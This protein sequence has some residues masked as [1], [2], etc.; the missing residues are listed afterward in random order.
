[1]NVKRWTAFLA[2]LLGVLL[3]AGCYY[4]PSGAQGPARVSMSLAKGLPVTPSSIALVVSGPGMETIAK[5]LAA[6]SSGS[7]SLE[8]PAGP[9]RTFTFLANTPSVTFKAEATVDLA[10]GETKEIFLSPVLSDT[11]IVVPDPY[12]NYRLVQISDMS[13][14]GWYAIQYNA[15]GLTKAGMTSLTQFLP[16]DVDFDAQG[17][18]YVANA[19]DGVVRLDSIYG[20][21]ADWF[22]RGA[23][24]PIG[25]LAIAVDRANQLLYYANGSSLSVVVT[26]PLGTPSTLTGSTSTNIT[27]LA[28]GPDGSLY[29]T[30]YGYGNGGFLIKYDPFSQTV[31]ASYPSALS[32]DWDPWDVTVQGGYVYTTHV[33]PFS[34]VKKVARSD[35]NLT[36]IDEYTGS[37]SDPFY[38]PRRF[39]AILSWKPTV[40][41]EGY[42]GS[43]SNRLATFGDMAG[44][45]WTTY[46]STGSSTGQF[47][48]F[49][50]YAC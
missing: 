41:D 38:G 16:Y 45:G 14:S 44:S 6:A 5:V 8:V 4:I 2:L 26:E 27:G 35:L 49:T 1:M 24:A 39:V 43:D 21:N 23:G 31:L 25:A 9:A 32:T 42:A 10:A 3:A 12:L 33:L 18:I 15:P 20:N 50:A 47:E 40:I 29:L 17:R 28:V 13:G 48:F 30:N 37:A 34:G 36:P 11:Q 7:E 22:A 19:Y 46:G